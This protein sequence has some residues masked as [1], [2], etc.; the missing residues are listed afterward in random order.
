M[1]IELY[2]AVSGIIGL[3]IGLM[4]DRN[5]RRERDSRISE[6]EQE[7]TVKQN[8]CEAQNDTINRLKKKLDRY[9]YDRT[10][11]DKNATTDIA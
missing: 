6:L 5:A 9:K 8:V 10:R 4:I 7:L 3:I 11:S 2:I 1:T